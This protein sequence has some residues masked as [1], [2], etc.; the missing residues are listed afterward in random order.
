M[1]I[2]KTIGIGFLTLLLF[3]SMSIGLSEEQ[4]KSFI[5]QWITTNKPSSISVSPQLKDNISFPNYTVQYGPVEIKILELCSDVNDLYTTISCRLYDNPENAYLVLFDYPYFPERHQDED[6]YHVYIDVSA[7]GSDYDA[8]DIQQLSSNHWILTVDINY[9]N[10]RSEWDRLSDNQP[11]NVDYSIEVRRNNEEDS[12]LM[13][14]KISIPYRVLPTIDYCMFN[15]RIIYEEENTVL[16][17]FSLYTTPLRI[18]S[19]YMKAPFNSMRDSFAIYRFF[20]E[21]GAEMN[22]YHESLPNVLYVAVYHNSLNEYKCTY[23][24]HRQ[25]NEYIYQETQEQLYKGDDTI[26]TSLYMNNTA[27]E[28]SIFCEEN[29]IEGSTMLNVNAA[30]I[31]NEYETEETIS[32]LYPDEQDFFVVPFIRLLHLNEC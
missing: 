22:Q 12:L 9:A 31:I 4:D 30:L 32:V 21:T 11:I 24:F 27:H 17:H 7:F 25:G 20:D 16:T 23:I 13:P 14:L 3:F 15:G 18:Y 26:F 8:F 19:E 28:I 5:V 1:H 29:P 2:K 6:I 10:G